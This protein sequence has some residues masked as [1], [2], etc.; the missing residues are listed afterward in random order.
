MPIKIIS[1]SLYDTRIIKVYHLAFSQRE[2]ANNYFAV[3]GYSDEPCLVIWKWDSD[4]LKDKIVFPLELPTKNYKHLQ[5]SFSV[6]KNDCFCIVSDQFFIYYNIN[7]RKLNTVHTFTDKQY[8][9]ILSHCWFFEGNF[10]IATEQSILIFD[11]AFKI[12]QQIDTYD[13]ISQTCVTTLHPLMDSFIGAGKNKRFEIYE[14]KSEIYEKTYPKSEER[15][16]KEKDKL[17]KEKLYDYLTLA[18]TSN[19]N[20]FVIA[21]TTSNDLI[22][23][24]L[25]DLDKQMNMKHLIAPFHCGSVEGLDVCI[26]KPYIITCSKDKYLRLWDYKKR[27]LVLSKFYEEEMYSVAYHPSGM[28]AIVSFEDKIMPMNI[29]YDEI[30]NMTQNGIPAKKSKDV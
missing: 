25:K 8:G 6:F 7:N 11:P 1:M 20:D 30:S 17:E 21:T 10:A 3:I 14:R 15:I 13:E 5:I 24:N 2:Q 18:S 4:A 19:N 26:N 27:S 29:Y 12:I 28:H 22:Q 16:D 23:I 9:A